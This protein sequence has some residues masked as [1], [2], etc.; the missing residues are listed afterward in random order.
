MMVSDGE[1][2]SRHRVPYD[3]SKCPA[4]SH[5]GTIP[6]RG[7]WPRAIRDFIMQKCFQSTSSY[8]LITGY[9]HVLI[10]Y[11]TDDIYCQSSPRSSR[12]SLGQAKN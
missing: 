4:S 2:L 3:D 5:K 1:T 10:S 8:Y 7:D 12:P 9:Q 6:A 11:M